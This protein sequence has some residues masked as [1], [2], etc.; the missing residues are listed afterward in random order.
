MCTCGDNEAETPEE[1][2][3]FLKFVRADTSDSNRD[4]QDSF[5]RKIQESMEEVRSSREMEEKFMLL[6]ELLKDERAEG[7][8]EGRAEGK[9][10]SILFLLQESGSVPEELRSKIMNE[11]NTDTLSKYL[12]LAA[13]AESITDFMK[14]IDK[15]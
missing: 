1:L 13:R 9:A 5:I 7:R 2:V 10:E 6:E 12:K 8:T 3:K 15:I 14:E 4:Y 11:Q